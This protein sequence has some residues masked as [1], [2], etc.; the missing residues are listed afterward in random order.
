MKI[1]ALIL[2]AALAGA[3]AAYAQG[4]GGG[5][6]PN[7]ARDAMMKACAPD[8]ASLCAGKEG[9]EANQ[10]LQAATG[11]VSPACADAMSKVPARGGGGGGPPPG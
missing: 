5:G 10:C 11:K 2:V 8:L 6:Q 4:G 1:S 3:G 9:R 7:P